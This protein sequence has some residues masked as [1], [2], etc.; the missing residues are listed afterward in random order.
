M[1]SFSDA[2]SLERAAVLNKYAVMSCDYAKGECWAANIRD[3]IQIIC[4]IKGGTWGSWHKR[5]HLTS[6]ELK[7]LEMKGKKS[8]FP[9][10]FLFCVL[11]SESVSI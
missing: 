7:E 9:S 2:N 1:K 11:I 4:V 5:S 3:L 8:V 10:A 6:L